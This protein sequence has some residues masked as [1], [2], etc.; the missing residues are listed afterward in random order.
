MTMKKKRDAGSKANVNEKFGSETLSFTS[1]DAGMN[2]TCDK[3]FFICH[4]GTT[5]SQVSPKSREDLQ[6]IDLLQLYLVSDDVMHLTIID[7]PKE[8]TSN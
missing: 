6:T 2:W 5:I 4:V 7:R 3:L 1:T 8:E